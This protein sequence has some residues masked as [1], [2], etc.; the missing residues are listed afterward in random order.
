M[1]KSLGVV[2]FSSGWTRNTGNGRTVVLADPNGLVARRKALPQPGELIFR[3]K[4]LITNAEGKSETVY[5]DQVSAISLDGQFRERLATIDEW[6]RAEDLPNTRQQI[7]SNRSKAPSEPPTHTEDAV[8]YQERV[9]AK[10]G[11]FW[12]E[13]VAL[14]SPNRAWLAVFSYSSSAKPGTS[15]SPLDGGALQEPRPG[16]L[17]VDVYNTSSRQR[18]QT[19]RV[20]YDG[21]PSMLFGGAFWV[22]DFYLIVPLDPLNASDAAG[23]ACWI[24]ILPTP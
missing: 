20:D 16:E 1:E 17:F 10:S 6:E 2:R 3:M 23:Q 14:L 9:F 12:G 13:P 7:R 15:W 8:R 22:G 11:E 24:S 5:S 4:G 21:S 18:I 19:G